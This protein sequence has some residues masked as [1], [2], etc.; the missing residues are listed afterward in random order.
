MSYTIQATPPDLSSVHGDLIYTVA[1]PEHTADPVTYTNYKFVGD[2]Y[3]NSVLVSRIKKIPNPETN[4]GIF[5]IGQ[6]VRNYVST[7]F[8]PTAGDIRS[9]VLSDG[10]FRVS[11][12]MKFGEEYAYTMYTNLVTDSTRTFFN[13]Y[14]GRLSGILTSL[15]GY[16]NK[17]LTTRPTA[18]KLRCDSSFNFPV[19]QNASSTLT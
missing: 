12:E 11:V 4:I 16:E 15:D 14:N 18:T 5:N 8:N 7:V 19:L 6:I 3:I 1:Y 9:Q 17:P 2:L 13:N 10:E